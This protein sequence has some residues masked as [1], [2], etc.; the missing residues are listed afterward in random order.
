MGLVRVSLSPHRLAWMSRFSDSEIILDCLFFFG[1]FSIANGIIS[2]DCAREYFLHRCTFCRLAV[3]RTE[4]LMIIVIYNICIFPRF[5]LY[6][7]RCGSRFFF[8]ALACIHH[9]NFSFVLLHFTLFF[10]LL[11][12]NLFIVVVVV[13]IIASL[14]VYLR[15]L[16]GIT[17]GDTG[18]TRNSTAETNLKL[19]HKTVLASFP[20]AMIQAF[21]SC[22]RSQQQRDTLLG[23]I[24]WSP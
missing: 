7:L 22:L 2:T 4:S 9:V 10:W 20:V 15:Y 17:S 5:T 16:D 11:I 24:A 3:F 19:H 13:A 1:F 18:I 8:C 6:N 12:L 14:V 21:G 23:S